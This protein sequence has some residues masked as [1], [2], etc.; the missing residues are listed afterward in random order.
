MR[1]IN[2]AIVGGSGFM[3][4]AHSLAWS[5]AGIDVPGLAVNKAVLVDV[6]Q[7]TAERSAAERGWA[8]ASTDLDAVLARDDIDVIDIVTPARLHLPVARAA[9][10]AGKH[11]FSEKPLTPDAG[12]AEELWRAAR[13]R[14]VVNQV[15]YC[16]RHT[17]AMTYA[18]ELVTSGRLGTP[19]QLRA[20]YLMD[21]A[22]D[23]PDWGRTESAIGSNDDIG[24]H[25]I[26]LAQHLLG[27]ITAVSARQHG[28][29]W[30]GPGAPATVVDAGALFL[31]EF[32][33]GAIGTFAH[34]VV[35]HGRKN[36]IQL[37]LDASGGAIEFDWNHRDEIQVAIPAPGQA[38][39][40]LSTVHMGP[41]HRGSWWPQAGMG[42]GYLEGHVTQLRGFL[43]AILEGGQAHPNFGEAAQVQR[44]A[45]AVIASAQTGAWVPVEPVDP[46]A[47]A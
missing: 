26:D 3:G 46:A 7:E 17:P 22:F 21:F 45:N 27:P 23:Y 38:Y 18:R 4:K 13:D 31:A 16:Y 24:T 25:V 10:A 2:V 39:A 8:E 33:C 35:A 41:E 28:R 5:L 6:D 29:T 44:V 30:E 32:A 11:V 19:I 20:S 36:E 40:A 34:S 43:T 37:E 42:S 14:G 9:I 12:D 15:G 47:L 1:T